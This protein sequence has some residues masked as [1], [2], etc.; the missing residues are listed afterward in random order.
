MK[1]YRS[2]TRGGFDENPEVAWVRYEDVKRLRESMMT[3][4][5]FQQELGDARGFRRA[6]IRNGCTPKSVEIL[7][8]EDRA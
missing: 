3:F 1:R 6:S 7:V 8:R 5:E 2:T 4:A